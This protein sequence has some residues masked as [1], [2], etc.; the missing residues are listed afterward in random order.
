MY[1]TASQIA[2]GVLIKCAISDEFIERAYEKKFV[3]AEKKFGLKGVVTNPKFNAEMRK[4]PRASR[5]MTGILTKHLDEMLRDA[6]K[7]FQGFKSSPIADAAKKGVA[8]SRAASNTASSAAGAYKAV[9][10]R[11][12]GGGGGKWGGL[13]GLAAGMAAAGGAFHLLSN[14]KKKKK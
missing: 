11:I 5:R 8:A 7:P 3:E 2:D 13:L 12:G 6:D 4:Y 9:A 1:K 14:K 10:P